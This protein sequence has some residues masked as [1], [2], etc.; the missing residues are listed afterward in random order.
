M[1][2]VH[3]LFAGL[4]AL[5]LVVT[6]CK[7]SGVDTSRLESSF[8][9]AEAAA[10]TS[11]EEAVTAIKAGD[12]AGGLAKLKSVADRVK[13][14]PEQEQAIKDVIAQLQQKLGDAAKKAGQEAG[15]AVEDLQKS[16]PR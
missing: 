2:I 4:A 16:L 7:K 15:K 6:G 12:Y 5:A 14:T 10:Q 1:K 13:L 8:K 11:V 9:S 3:I